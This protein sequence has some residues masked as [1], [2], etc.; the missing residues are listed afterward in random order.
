V[1]KMS[2]F[3]VITI[4]GPAGLRVILYCY[5]HPLF[6]NRIARENSES[7]QV[8]KSAFGSCLSCP[9]LLLG[10]SINTVLYC[11]RSG[12]HLDETF[13]LLGQ[14][15]RLHSHHPILPYT[16]LPYSYP[17]GLPCPDPMIRKDTVLARNRVVESCH[18]SFFRSFTCWGLLC[19]PERW[20]PFRGDISALSQSPVQIPL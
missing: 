19:L 4:L 20:S 10:L 16:Y 12:L 1:K 17:S 13:L 5:R 9:T 8:S 14:V 7:L 11:S 15:H 3:C 2:H 18:I 6:D